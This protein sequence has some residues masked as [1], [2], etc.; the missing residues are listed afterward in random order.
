MAIPKEATNHEGG[1]WE[2]AELRKL[3]GLGRRSQE[4]WEGC[5]GYKK[6]R[7]ARLTALAWSSERG[8]DFG[9][10]LDLLLLR[11][12]RESPLLEIDQQLLGAHQAA[13]LSAR[14]VLGT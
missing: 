8:F 10:S 3:L 14:G 2:S 12:E 5:E 4:P 6:A 13:L 9:C 11:Q 1:C 7:G